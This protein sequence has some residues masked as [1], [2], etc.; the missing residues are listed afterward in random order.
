MMYKDVVLPLRILILFYKI[1]EKV[2][3][4]DDIIFVPY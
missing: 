2:E 3:K 1:I 4:S